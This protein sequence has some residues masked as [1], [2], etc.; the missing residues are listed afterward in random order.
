MKI[1]GY[2]SDSSEKKRV[3]LALEVVEEILSKS[4][5]VDDFTIEHI[6]ADS[7]GNESSNI[8][9][10][11]P[12]EDDLNQRCK[13]KQLKDKIYIYKDSKF[14]SARHVYERYGDGGVEFVAGK[15]ADYLAQAIY[16]DM[17]D[18]KDKLIASLKS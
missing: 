7:V 16:K 15:R 5:R 11:I 4:D 1:I 13:D 10:L 14:R 18:S 8:G 6:V 17:M 12:L 2:H 3:Q 9:N